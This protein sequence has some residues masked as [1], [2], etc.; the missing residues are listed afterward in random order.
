MPHCFALPLSVMSPPVAA[1]V[2]IS[3]LESRLIPFWVLTAA[4]RNTCWPLEVLAIT[5]TR[6]V[7]PLKVPMETTAIVPVGW[8]PQ[9]PVDSDHRGQTW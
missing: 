8:V 9:V 7:T 2:S 1:D 3:E 6:R 5:S 4:S